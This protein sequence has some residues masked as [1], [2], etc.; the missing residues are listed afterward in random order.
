MLQDLNP[1]TC[2]SLAIFM[3]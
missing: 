2:S 1:S 3:H